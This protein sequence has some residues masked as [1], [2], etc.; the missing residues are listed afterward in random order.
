[1][2][3][4][5][6]TQKEGAKGVHT[7]E[8]QSREGGRPLSPI[9]SRR[10]KA[11]G[12]PQFIEGLYQD[13]DRCQQAVQ[14]AGG[15]TF[16]HTVE[17]DVVLQEHDG[18]SSIPPRI[19]PMST[20]TID[21]SILYRPENAEEGKNTRKAGKA[22]TRTSGKLTAGSSAG[23]P[24][25]SQDGQ[26]GGAPA[27]AGFRLAKGRYSKK[28]RKHRGGR[29]K[30]R[31]QGFLSEQD[32]SE[33]GQVTNAEE[34]LSVRIGSEDLLRADKEAANPAG[35][36]GSGDKGGFL[37]GFLGC[38][39]EKAQGPVEARR[40]RSTGEEDDDEEEESRRVPRGTRSTD[41]EDVD[42][43]EESRRVPRKKERDAQDIGP[44]RRSTQVTTVEG[45]VLCRGNK[46]PRY[47]RRAA[48]GMSLKWPRRDGIITPGMA[49]P[50]RNIVG[51]RSQEEPMVNARTSGVF[52]ATSKTRDNRRFPG[53]AEK[54]LRRQSLES[55]SAGGNEVGGEGVDPLLW[56][57]IRPPEAGPS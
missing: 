31:K 7:L 52:W 29:N 25:D 15:L 27:G 51:Y 18:N 36:G 44:R 50:N 49:D 55:V 17:G 40:A 22:K 5:T 56:P 6:S 3:V 24:P 20:S 45:G 8:G 34:E 19:P 35:P 2:G 11:P 42:E 48:D 41:E 32:F 12:E 39:E 1:M 37:T 13:R 4:V 47:N 30:R 16:A 21:W 57:G 54:T 28:R 46:G 14:E 9:G 23:A 26:P 38:S 33:Y 53:T 10:R 43:E